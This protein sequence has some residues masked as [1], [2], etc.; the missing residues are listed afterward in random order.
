M[1]PTAVIVHWDIFLFEIIGVSSVPYIGLCPVYIFKYIWFDR[2]ADSIIVSAKFLVSGI[3]KP[4]PRGESL[5]Q[6]Q[7]HG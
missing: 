6:R 5:M 4:K 2:N 3:F 1:N 7:R